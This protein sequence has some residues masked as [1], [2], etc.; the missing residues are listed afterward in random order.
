M[1]VIRR[2]RTWRDANVWP[3]REIRRLKQE[4]GSLTIEQA[5]LQWKI[6]TVTADRDKAVCRRRELYRELEST[7]DRVLELAEES[8]VA[9]KERDAL[10]SSIASGRYMTRNPSTGR[11]E[12]VTAL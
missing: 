3:W 10:R 9:K 2:L 8:A 4:I 11:F 6:D 7:V 1:S 5:G 12:R